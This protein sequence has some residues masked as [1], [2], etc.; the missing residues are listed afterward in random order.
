MEPSEPTPHMGRAADGL[1]WCGGHSVA[2]S[3]AAIAALIAAWATEAGSF[4]RGPGPMARASHGMQAAA[5]AAASRMLTASTRAG[6]AA[7]DMGIIA[8]RRGPAG[9]IAAA[10]GMAVSIQIMAPDHQRMQNGRQARM[11]G[12]ARIGQNGPAGPQRGAPEHRR[13]RPCRGGGL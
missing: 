12:P 7:R 2:S 9:G 3:I 4:T 1:P 5:Q 11:P 10:A 6:V 8:P 13:L